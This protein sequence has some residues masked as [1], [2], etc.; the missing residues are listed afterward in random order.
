RTAGPGEVPDLTADVGTGTA[1]ITIR[2]AGR[3]DEWAAGVPE[4]IGTMEHIASWRRV[5]ELRNPVT[6]LV[7]PV[8]VEL[9]PAA[10]GVDLA[11]ATGA[12]MRPD[13]DDVYRLAYR[14][15]GTDWVAPEIFIRLHN[16]TG[17]ELWCL[18]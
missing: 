4:A 3:D 9:V 17:R 13:G 12:A 14:R 7:D 8:A 5:R 16:T 2:Q 11:P 1:P 6:A 15:N 10:P 18:L